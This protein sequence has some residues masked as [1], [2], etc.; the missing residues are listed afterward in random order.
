[1]VSFMIAILYCVLLNLVTTT[2]GSCK[3]DNVT[4]VAEVRIVNVNMCIF[5]CVSLIY[6]NH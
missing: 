3:P 6:G 5:L 4:C 2:N 1:M